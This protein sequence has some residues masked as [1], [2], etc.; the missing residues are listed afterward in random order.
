M[1]MSTGPSKSATWLIVTWF[2]T[3][4]ISVVQLW[5]KASDMEA[6]VAAATYAAVPVV[7][8]GTS[9]DVIKS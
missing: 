2:I 4:F 1:I 3:L 9:T 7:F 8:L 5:F 6:L